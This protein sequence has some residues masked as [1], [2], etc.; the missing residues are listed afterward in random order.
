MD[1]KLAIFMP[2]RLASERLPNK[3]ILPLGDSSLWEMACRK[4]NNLP[5]KYGK[6]VL[7]YD[8]ELINIAKKYSNITIIKR[9][10]ATTKIDGPLT[11][12]FTGV[13]DIDA[14][15]LMFLNPCLSFITEQTLIKSLEQFEHSIAEYATSVKL[16]QNWLFASKPRKNLTEIDY[17]TLSTKDI[18]IY[19]EAA[20]VFHIFNKDRFFEDGMMLKDD[21]MLISVPKNETID[22]DT[23][24]DYEYARF[25]HAKRYIFDIDGTI[26]TI[27]Y[28]NYIKAKPFVNRIEKV[29]YLYDAGNTIIFQTARGFG[30]GIDQKALTEKQLKQWEVKY[31]ELYFNKP[32]GDVYID[33]KGVN[34]NQFFN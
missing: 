30:S 32:H 24:E 3:L 13:K 16:Y 28:P 10:V 8:A 6:Y 27:E 18:P 17:K 4:L 26:C 14:T 5:E 34:D 20:H 25:K 29:N 12:I 9:D 23:Q 7:I 1:R 33:D 31:H 21:H 22:V 15:H 19:H 2:G 11:K